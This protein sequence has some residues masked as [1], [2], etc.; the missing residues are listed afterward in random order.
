MKTVSTRHLHSGTDSFIL[1]VFYSVE[2]NYFGLFDIINFFQRVYKAKI[3][4]YRS[5]Q[6]KHELLSIVF[7]L[8]I[9]KVSPI[10][11]EIIVFRKSIAFH[12]K[13]VPI[14]SL[15]RWQEVIESIFH[16]RFI[17]FWETIIRN[18]LF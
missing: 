1:P 9:G 7:F 2:V 12:Y 14:L 11:G 18:K 13:V 16:G 10:N 15:M 17:V 3:I 8:I 4:I 5:K 6:L